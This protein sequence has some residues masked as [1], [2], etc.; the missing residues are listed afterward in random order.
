MILVI[1]M[2][3]IEFY[4]LHFVDDQ[5]KEHKC[6]SWNAIHLN[7]DGVVGKDTNLTV[8]SALAMLKAKMR[9]HIYVLPEVYLLILSEIVNYMCTSVTG[10]VYT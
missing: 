4:N 10:H 6:C 3:W 2:K 9:Q 7:Y 1:S 8:P 5:C